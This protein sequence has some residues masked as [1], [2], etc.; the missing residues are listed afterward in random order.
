MQALPPGPPSARTDPIAPA[1]SP[2]AVVVGTRLDDYAG[3]L[4]TEQDWLGV[5]HAVQRLEHDTGTRLFVTF[6]RSFGRLDGQTWAHEA[7][8]RS[9]L[10]QRD[11]LLA[12]AIDDRRY[13]VAVVD[14]I[15]ITWSA[16]SSL[17]ERDVAARVRHADWA[18]TA[19]TLA[20]GL[21]TADD[22]HP[23]GELV[24]ACVVGGL[25]GVL[26]AC[27]IGGDATPLGWWW[28]R[29]RR[30]RA[31]SEPEDQQPGRRDDTASR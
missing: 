5:Q 6:V 8:R 27:I 2:A 11:V 9:G 25:V 12:V 30:S 10:T 23:G 17:V 13:G 20:D 18:G 21:R 19:V 3:V 24:V 15:P 31:T 29:R 4:H 7:K 28:R 16:F 1:D 26:A 14:Q 22:A